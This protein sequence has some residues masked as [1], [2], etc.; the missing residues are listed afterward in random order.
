MTNGRPKMELES[1]RVTAPLAT[2]LGQQLD[3][4]PGGSLVGERRSRRKRR[5]CMSTS[6][7]EEDDEH[8]LL[9]IERRE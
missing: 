9:M 3:A 2:M 8:R 1:S 6:L 4:I 5:R 7:L